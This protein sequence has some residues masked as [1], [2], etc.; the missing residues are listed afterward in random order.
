ML[1]LT[2]AVCP[3]DMI[4][5]RLWFVRQ[6]LIGMV[7]RSPREG[8]SSRNNRLDRV[9]TLIQSQPG[10]KIGDKL[11]MSQVRRGRQRRR[12]S[13]PAQSRGRRRHTLVW[14]HQDVTSAMEVETEGRNPLEVWVGIHGCRK[15][16]V[17]LQICCKSVLI[18]NRF[19]KFRYV[20]KSNSKYLRQP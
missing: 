18:Y 9:D 2:A 4:S 11:M 19:W 12:Q 6:L 13:V 7:N 16:V 8:P 5:S 17:N 15:S 3:N 14:K 10:Q 20:W 1:Y